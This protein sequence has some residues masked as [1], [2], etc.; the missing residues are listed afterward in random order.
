MRNLASPKVRILE[1]DL[2]EYYLLSWQTVAKKSKYGEMRVKANRKKRKWMCKGRN[3][4][5]GSVF[6][7]PGRIVRLFLTLSLEN[8]K[9][10]V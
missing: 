5:V 2:V 6:E 7:R 4:P 9:T 8:G 3:G 10:P 1:L